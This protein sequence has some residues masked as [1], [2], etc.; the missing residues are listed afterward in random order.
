MINFLNFRNLTKRKI[1]AKQNISDENWYLPFHK[2][3]KVGTSSSRCFI[4]GGALKYTGEIYHVLVRSSA[5][6]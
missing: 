5:K 1:S 4:L 3:L 6:P 2:I